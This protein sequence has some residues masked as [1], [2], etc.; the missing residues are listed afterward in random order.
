LTEGYEVASAE[1]DL[2]ARLVWRQLQVRAD[3][4]LVEVGWGPEA[5]TRNIDA[6]LCMPTAADS[7]CTIVGWRLLAAD[8]DLPPWQA[9]RFALALRGTATAP[10]LIPLLLTTGESA[11]CTTLQGGGQPRQ[12]VEQVVPAGAASPLGGGQLS[13]DCAV[14]VLDSPQP[15]DEVR[16]LVVTISS[17][18]S[19]N[20]RMSMFEEPTTATSSSPRRGWHA[21]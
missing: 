16:P 15:V 8:L 6:V 10:G 18:F 14:A 7:R 9:R 5:A 3:A 12:V 19:W 13:G 17:R 4:A 11:C 1:V 2:A 21:G 20:D